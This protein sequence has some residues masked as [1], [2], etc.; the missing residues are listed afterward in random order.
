[1]VVVVVVVVDVVVLVVAT[2]VPTE[3]DGDV[4]SD[5]PPSCQTMMAALAMTTRPTTVNTATRDMSHNSASRIH[6][7]RATPYHPCVDSTEQL[8]PV[9]SRILGALIE[10]AATTPDS[11]PLSSNALVAACNQSTNRDPVMD[12][13]EREVDA[14]MMDLRQ[15]GLA[16]TLSGAGHRVPKHRHIVDEAMQLEEEDLAVLAVLLL[17]GAQ[18]LNEITTRTE[19]YTDGPDGDAEAVNAAIDRLSARSEP[20]VVRLE[21]K[22]GEREPRIDELWSAGSASVGEV[23][24]EPTPP[25]TPT[26]GP[27]PAPMDYREITVEDYGEVRVITLNRPEK[28]NAWTH[29]MNHEL[30]NAFLVGN[31]DPAVGAFVVTGAGRGFCAGADITEVF[32]NQAGRDDRPSHNW[33]DLMRTSKP[34]VGAINGASIGVGLTLTLSMDFLIAHPD[35][36]LSMRF[37]KMGVV[38]EL[39]SSHFLV[40]RCG[41][42]SASDL[43]LSGR[44]V[45]GVEAKE[46]GLVDALADDVLDAAVDRAASYAENAPPSIRLSKDLLT[47]NATD[48]DLR[49]VQRRELKALEEAYA[50][51]DHR[52]AVAAF[53]ERRPPKFR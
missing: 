2:S 27:P 20:L 18:T 43:V 48:S 15:R 12:V 38:P 53:M 34:V 39:A 21:R 10:K 6:P 29:T 45:L 11:Y 14:V 33:V 17:R 28:L 41:W 16:R 9:E 51:A 30:V 31:A 47:Q 25:P 32:A 36:K 7:N 24:A 42:G 37:V 13:S 4:V 52:E 8:N 40:Q 35:A 46:L 3:V 44:T 26:S 23:T 50:T 5:S 49:A 1:M 19:R 22:P